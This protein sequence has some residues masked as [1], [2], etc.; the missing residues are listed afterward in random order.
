MDSMDSNEN[1]ENQSGTD[2]HQNGTET[3][4]KQTENAIAHID[5]TRPDSTVSGTDQTVETEPTLETELTLDKDAYNLELNQA[6][7]SIE[8]PNNDTDDVNT[9]ALPGLETEKQR[10]CTCKNGKHDQY[11]WYYADR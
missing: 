4:T 1:S 7:A 9:P 3:G 5:V 6:V 10:K 2:D 8:E 11:S